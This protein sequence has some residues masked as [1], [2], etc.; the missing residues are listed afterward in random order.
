MI[1]R[2]LMVLALAV[3]SYYAFGKKTDQQHK[4]RISILTGSAPEGILRM[5]QQGD[6]IRVDE[7]TKGFVGLQYMR[8]VSIKEDESL[9]I[10]IQGQSNRTWGVGV[11]IGF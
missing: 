8:D 1:F 4:N 6:T 3:S 10:L 7:R 9:H 5:S 2:I 11:G